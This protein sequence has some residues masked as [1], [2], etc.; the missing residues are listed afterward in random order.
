MSGSGGCLVQGAGGWSGGYLVQ[1][2]YLVLG[3]VLSPWGCLVPGDVVQG[4]VWFQGGCGLGGIWS[5]GGLVLG[6][7]IP[8]CT[9]EAPPSPENRMTD[10]CKSIALATTSLQPVKMY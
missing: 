3:G 7:G 5:Q 4:G 6:G 1:E 8:A 10:R 9:E 2:V